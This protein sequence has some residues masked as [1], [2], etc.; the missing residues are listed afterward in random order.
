MKIIYVKRKEKGIYPQHWVTLQWDGESFFLGNS[1][2]VVV[3]NTKEAGKVVRKAEKDLKMS[4]KY[5]T[6]PVIIWEEKE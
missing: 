3:E 2:N 6:E 4:F 1:K 5:M